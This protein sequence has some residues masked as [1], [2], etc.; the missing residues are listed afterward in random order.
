MIGLKDHRCPVTGRLC[1]RGECKQF[2]DGR[3]K[4][5][6]IDAILN[7]AFELSG[8]A[9]MITALGNLKFE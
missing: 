6:K 4:R 2:V 3:F 5:C 8:F 1:M 9:N 7:S